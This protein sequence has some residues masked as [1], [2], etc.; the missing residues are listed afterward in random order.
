MRLTR[1]ASDRSH[2]EPSRSRTGSGSG[3]APGV[4]L[5]CERGSVQAPQVF[6]VTSG[7]LG[8]RLW[9]GLRFGAPSPAGRG[10]ARVVIATRRQDHG[11][12]EVVEI[13]LDRPLPL[14]T[15]RFLFDD[16]AVV[17][18][19]VCTVV[20]GG[21]TG[22]DDRLDDNSDDIPDRLQAPMPTVMTWGAMIVVL[23]IMVAQKARR[24]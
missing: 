10:G 14:G 23:G 18:E 15:T 13:V 17:N 19:V 12:S 24:S 16:G 22:A 6:A 20:N 7:A 1:R 21:E 2:T 3:S 9:S 11:S 4:L 8:S 5:P